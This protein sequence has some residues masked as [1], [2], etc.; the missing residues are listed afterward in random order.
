M[1]TARPSD[2]H[3]A[4]GDREERCKIRTDKEAVNRITT[5]WLENYVDD[6]GGDLSLLLSGDNL[7]AALDL[8]DEMIAEG[9]AAARRDVLE[10]L[11]SLRNLFALQR[12]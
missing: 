11:A 4:A 10:E 9:L 12:P 6:R 1:Q 2:E 7:R 8:L 5:R 3:R